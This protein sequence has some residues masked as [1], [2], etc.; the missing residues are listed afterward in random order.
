M[1]FKWLGK[2][3]LFFMSTYR[4]PNTGASTVSTSALYP[5]F[6]HLLINDLV[7]SL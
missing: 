5:A 6:S 2:V 3:K 4:I 1:Y 7:K